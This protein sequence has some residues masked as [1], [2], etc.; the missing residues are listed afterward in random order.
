M[1]KTLLQVATLL[2][3]IPT[4]RYLLAETELWIRSRHV[5]KGTTP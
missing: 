4:S 5:K 3:L 1:T 2:L